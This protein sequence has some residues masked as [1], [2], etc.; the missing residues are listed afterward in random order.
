MPSQ[1]SHRHT[2]L[3]CYA[4]YVTQAIVNNFAPLLFLAL[5]GEF[6]LSL[7]D[8]TL[9]TTVNFLVQL[10]VDLVSAGFVD[11][12][13]YRAAVV[14]AHAFSAAGL[15][16][17]GVLPHVLASPYLGLLLSVALYAVG[18]GLIEVLISPIV[19]GCPTDD[20]VA[21]MSLLHSFYC[22]GHVGVVLVSTGFFLAF[23]VGA[24]PALACAWALLP[25][26]NCL[27]FA[28]VPIYP[29][30]GEG[31]GM[32]VR[33]LLRTPAFWALVLLMVCSGASEQ[34]MSQW[35]STFAEAGLSLPKAA[36]DVLGPC[37]FAT[38]MGTSRALFGRAGERLPLERSIALCASLCVGAYLLAGLSS[39]PALGLLGCAACGL[40]VGIFWPGTFSLAARRMPRG[41]TGLFAL[42]ALAGDLGC[43]GG[44]TLVGLVA[45]A[46]EGNLRPG[47]LA[48][49]V[50]PA[51]ILVALGLS[52]R[53]RGTRNG[54]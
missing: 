31:E 46:C 2:I 8:I 49:A 48:A 34:G 54:E 16:S 17:L 41:G 29:L 22:W 44:P 21:A 13:G 18:G 5:S 38:L 26:A 43:S 1:L 52:G 53:G 4:G 14:A 12:I 47:L 3:A 6:G 40:S 27:L 39:N 9:L 23:G 50:F 15:V 30:V 7:A 45:G 35:A 11:R 19:E 24:W 36:G 20:K 51:L 32:R 37:L 42:L 10:L 33:D 25:L 28:R